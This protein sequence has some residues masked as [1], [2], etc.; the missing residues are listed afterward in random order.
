MLAIHGC[1][2]WLA[3]TTILVLVQGHGANQALAQD[4]NASLRVAIAELILSGKFAD[5]EPRAKEWL[6]LAERAGEQSP[7]VAD[8]LEA[9]IKIYA[10][11]KRFDN[12]E[13]AWRR[14]LELRVKNVG[15]KH[16]LIT[17]TI[18]IMAGIYSD[19]GRKA[20]AQALWREGFAAYRTRPPVAA[21]QGK[22]NPVDK[23]HRTVPDLIAQGRTRE[24]E[25]ALRRSGDQLS[26][27][28][29]LLDNGRSSEAAIIHRSLLD[30]APTADRAISTATLYRQ[31][32]LAKLEQEFLEK[33]VAIQEKV[34]GSLH[35]DLIPIL[36][37]LAQSYERQNELA[38]AYA[39]LKRATTIVGNVRAKQAFTTPPAVALR[40]RQP[41][42]DFL[43]IA[44]R[45]GR[46][47]PGQ[48]MDLAQDTFEAGQLVTETV[49]NATLAQMW[50]RQSKGGG[51]LA[52]LIRNRQDLER[53]WQRLDRLLL[54]AV[55]SA[56]S[57]AER[58]GLRSQISTAERR[59]TAVDAQLRRDF[60]QYFEFAMPAPLVVA[61]A[62]SLL[63]NSEALVQFAVSGEQAYVWAVTKS[64]ARWAVLAM[65]PADIEVA[66]AALRC[67]LD[68]E[69]SWGP[70]APAETKQRCRELVKRTYTEADSSVPRPMPFD[71]H[72]AHQLYTGLFAAMEDVIAGK[73]LLLVPS[74]PLSSLPFHALVTRRAGT[75]L[76]LDWDGYARASWLATTHA[77]TVLPSVASLKFLRQQAGRSS[78]A[79]PY[80]A[81]AN[82]LLTG[83]SGN[84]RRAALRQDCDERGPGPQRFARAPA[85]RAIP[86]RY[87]RGE[88]AIAE[89]VRE[90][91]PLVET[92]DE[93]CAVARQVDA[94]PSDVFLGPKATERT[95]KSLSSS[96]VLEQ[97]R[98]I[99]F[100][101]HGL[102]AS[103]TEL[104][105]GG[106][107]EPALVLTPPA[108]ASLEDDGLLTSGDILQLQLNADLVILS[109]CNTAGGE[110]A[111]ADA[112]SGLARAFFYAGSRALLVSHWAVD[113]YATV[114]LVTGTFDS[115]RDT[116]TVGRAQALRKA[117]RSMIATGN[118][119]AHP[120]YWSPFVVVGE[121]GAQ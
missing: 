30:L 89:K 118:E 40:M 86:A 46:D 24:A 51:P 102:L 106:P 98:V 52:Q 92:A 76:P 117:I 7:E 79:K 59:L 18:D 109:A 72:R 82:P 78:A 121:G 108:Q 77:T 87:F 28:T 96:G 56:S 91:V 50:H 48:L 119:G 23:S 71:L 19:Q 5:A 99:H 34:L 107:A 62:Q 32:N 95:V 54:S 3:L 114:T 16:A 2:K 65:K 75:A 104:A 63:R 100:A 4:S 13:A 69:G 9:L 36:N 115:L 29:F 57:Q 90:L 85:A 105:A 97:Y 6:A 60:P 110:R 49:L 70:N 73:E 15:A 120:A 84:D 116:P 11:L 111:G 41:Q 20:E 67:G 31:R 45:L 55:T 26:L 103:E 64:T 43:R 12:S 81:F 25:D 10:G 88:I 101:T 93:V 14:C 47:N 38:K 53:E 22:S 80:L 66:V 39:V 83:P 21:L 8:A 112:L 42:L 35:G 61:E 33:G 58:D 68:Y 1:M 74:G 27:A 44:A 17:H 113:S 94:P 37:A